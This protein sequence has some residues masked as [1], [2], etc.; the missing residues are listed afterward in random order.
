MSDLRS[1]TTKARLQAY[2][3]ASGSAPPEDDPAEYSHYFEL[4]YP[5]ERDRRRFLETFLSAASP[6]WGHAA[7]AALIGSDL[8]RVV[9]TTN[10]DRLVEEA[11]AKVPGAISGLRVA[12]LA[13]PE[14]AADAFRDESWPILVKLHGDFH[15]RRLKNTAEELRAQD[16]SLRAVLAES[17]RRF[18]LVVAGYSG[19]DT[20]V[21]DALRQG[22]HDGA[23]YPG[24]LFWMARDGDPLLA[25][26]LALIS[27]AQEQGIDAHVVRAPTFDELASDVC[28]MFNVA[29]RTLESTV[30]A[31]RS[32]VSD[33]PIPTAGSGWPTVRLNAY[34]LSSWPQT[35][36][37]IRCDA[38]GT[39]EVREALRTSGGTAIGI[40]KRS[41]VVGFGRDEDFRKAFA[42][43]NIT[44][45]DLHP[46]PEL[47]PEYL[48]LLTDALGIALARNRAV[49]VERVGRRLFV[50]VDP[51]DTAGPS[52]TAL[53]RATRGALS[54][55]LPGVELKWFEAA[56]VRLEE[57]L[58]RLWFLVEP[59]IFLTGLREAE[60]AARAQAREFVRER[61]ASRYNRTWNDLFEA[62]SGVLFEGRQGLTI[63][64]FGTSAGVD[65]E[66]S[67]S[68]VTA[69]SRRETR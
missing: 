26:V 11:C 57:R 52:Y 60:D 45:L 5:D 44:G 50:L 69:F 15:Y 13:A 31:R 58:G 64:A 18:G 9:W 29:T 21:M 55:T 63:S 68:G 67:V 47:R 24:G 43:A 2:F 19:R 8:V 32:L 14:K 27:A 36:R 56:R 38:G 41:G 4:A 42:G 1:P 33:A 17:A 10:F 61:M 34:P 35:C 37:L 66:F 30:G 6:S 46:I 53:R 48:G 16:A 62:W 20:S 22:I 65:A 3:D 28:Q 12:D 7:L 51:A 23:G 40:R 54:G 49:L 25:E 39:K 59:T